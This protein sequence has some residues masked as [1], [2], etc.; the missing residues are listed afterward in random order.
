MQW[1]RG[2]TDQS[3]A[4]IEIVLEGGEYRHIGEGAADLLRGWIASEEIEC[5]CI[6]CMADMSFFLEI[7]VSLDRL[8]QGPS[9]L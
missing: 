1:L 4:D 3:D 8:S 5:D 2:T 7:G 9:M 6:S